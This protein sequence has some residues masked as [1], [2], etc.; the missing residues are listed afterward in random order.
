MIEWGFLKCSNLTFT[1]IPK[2]LIISLCGN[3]LEGSGTLSYVIFYLLSDVYS[4]NGTWIGDYALP[5]GSNY[6]IQAKVKVQNKAVY[7]YGDN[8]SAQFNN[9]QSGYNYYYGYV[10]MG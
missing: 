6:K 3:Y 9:N 4:F 5:I 2:V 8:A 1:F 7:W 10:G